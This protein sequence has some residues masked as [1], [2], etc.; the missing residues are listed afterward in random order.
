MP[1][2]EP[3]KQLKR[4]G[5]LR[6]ALVLC[7]RAIEGAEQSAEGREP[8]PAYTEH[9]AIIHRKLGEHDL[10]VA[11]LQCWLDHAPDRREGS[12]IA[13]RLVKLQR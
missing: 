1:K 2:N 12:K 3:I 7:Y 8:A 13:E 11:V 10:E 5:R 4:E 6:E 9:A